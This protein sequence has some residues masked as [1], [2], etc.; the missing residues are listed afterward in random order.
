MY[1]LFTPQVHRKEWSSP[2]RQH[3][4]GEWTIEILEIGV[5]EAPGEFWFFMEEGGLQRVF[6][7]SGV[8]WSKLSSQSSKIILMSRE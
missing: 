1:T 7:Y 3:K 8:R 4:V 6:F 2:T 5:L